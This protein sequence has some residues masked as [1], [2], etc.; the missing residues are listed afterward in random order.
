[1]GHFRGGVSVNT[2][3]E[4]VDGGEGAASTTFD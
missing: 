1:M 3:S 2:Y 4:K